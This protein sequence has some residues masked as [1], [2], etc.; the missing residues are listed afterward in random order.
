MVLPERYILS[1]FPVFLAVVSQLSA[2]LPC[3]YGACG[4]SS[5]IFGVMV[6]VVQVFPGR[7][8]FPNDRKARDIYLLLVAVL[9]SFSAYS[10]YK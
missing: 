5:S 2:G 9:S 6:Y 8:W 7:C 3:D 10:V 1:P 4:I